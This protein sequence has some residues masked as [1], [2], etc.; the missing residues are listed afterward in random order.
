M[1]KKQTKKQ[2]LKVQ[3]SKVDLTELLTVLKSFIMEELLQKETES[4]RLASIDRNRLQ[5]RI[6]RLEIDLKKEKQKEQ[7]FGLFKASQELKRVSFCPHEDRFESI[8]YSQINNHV[9]GLKY[10]C[11]WC[12]RETI[13][14]TILLTRREKR[15][16]KKLGVEI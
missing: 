1:V 16:L 5:E 13:K 12:G 6:T 10:K 3:L 14:T 15:V 8:W 11:K 9:M 2:P 7:R 4:E